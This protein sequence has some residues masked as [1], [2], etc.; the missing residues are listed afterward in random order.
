MNIRVLYQFFRTVKAVLDF[1]AEKLKG[2][3]NLHNSRSS[4]LTDFYE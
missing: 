3:R 1:E 4:F 2:E